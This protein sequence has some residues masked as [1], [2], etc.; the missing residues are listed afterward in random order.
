MD[1]KEHAEKRRFCD[2]DVLLEINIV[3]LVNLWISFDFF[4]FSQHKLGLKGSICQRGHWN[5]SSIIGIHSILKDGKR[6]YQEQII[7]SLKTCR[8]PS[9]IFL[10][11]VIPCTQ[12]W[13]MVYVSFM[14]K[15]AI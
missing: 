10:I 15:R 13:I 2:N 7:L 4:Q 14:E 12:Q 5:Y 9:Y 3:Y 8:V 6:N 11:S 1:E